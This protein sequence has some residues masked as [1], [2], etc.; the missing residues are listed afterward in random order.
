MKRWNQEKID[1]CVSL[2]EQGFSQEQIAEK[3]KAGQA[4][5]CKIL[6][7]GGIACRF[8][9]WSHSRIEKMLALYQSGVSVG[10][11]ARKIHTNRQ[12]VRKYLRASGVEIRPH[13]EA[14]GKIENNPNWKGGRS[15]GE[16]IYIRCPDHPHCNWAGY[17]LEHRLVMEKHLG[18]YLRSKEVVHHR[19]G[20]KHNNGIENLQLFASNGKHLAFEL[21]GKCPKW[22]EEGRQRIVEAHRLWCRQQR[23]KNHP[24]TGVH[25]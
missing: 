9:P 1:L 13:S 21:K 15:V 24:K 3:L 14:T 18:R 2:Y 4:H 11:T 20:N 5:V 10:E 25:R 16:Y 22:T 8:A 23:R 12:T 17:V 7:E 6:K 19:D